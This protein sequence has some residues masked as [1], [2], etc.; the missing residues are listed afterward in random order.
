MNRIHYFAMSSTFFTTPQTDQMHL[1]TVNAN[2][3][4][5]QL[6]IAY[7]IRNACSFTLLIFNIR[8]MFLTIAYSFTPYGLL[9]VSGDKCEMRKFIRNLMHDVWL[10]VLTCLLDNWPRGRLFTHIGCCLRVKFIFFVFFFSSMNKLLFSSGVNSTEEERHLHHLSD[11]AAM[12]W[13]PFDTYIRNS[14]RFQFWVRNRHAIDIQCNLFRSWVMFRC[15]WESGHEIINSEKLNEAVRK[16]ILRIV[17]AW[18]P[19]FRLCDYHVL[20]CFTKHNHY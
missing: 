5:A 17:P 10:C 11:E 19:F 1:P 20:I 15:H 3:D 2:S 18:F 16:F 12:S 14:T 9:A 7:A 6:W 4:L 13:W 8:W